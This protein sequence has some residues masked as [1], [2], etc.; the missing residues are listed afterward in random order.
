M[1]STAVFL[2]DREHC[3][4]NATF[5]FHQRDAIF[6]L[7]E[8]QSASFSALELLLPPFLQY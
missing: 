7:T 2:T 6:M 8:I 5:I 1:L 3:T 4:K